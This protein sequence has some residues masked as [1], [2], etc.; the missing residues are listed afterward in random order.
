MHVGRWK[1]QIK[2]NQIQHLIYT[3]AITRYSSNGL[4]NNVAQQCWTYML[5][6][7][8]TGHKLNVWQN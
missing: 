3:H 2:L 5:D 1:S 8:T 7:Y 6:L 4:A